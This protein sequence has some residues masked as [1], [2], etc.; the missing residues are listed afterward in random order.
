MDPINVQLFKPDS[1]R[2]DEWLVKWTNSN[3]NDTVRNNYTLCAYQ[4]KSDGLITIMYPYS[5]STY[6]SRTGV[7]ALILDEDGNLQI[8]KEW[9]VV[10]TSLNQAVTDGTSLSGIVVDDNL[11]MLHGGSY[12]GFTGCEG[13]TTTS[14][15]IVNLYSTGAPY[16]SVGRA[17]SN[18]EGAGPGMVDRYGYVTAPSANG[19]RISLIDSEATTAVYGST[20]SFRDGGTLIFPST[21]QWLGGWKR[22]RTTNDWNSTLFCAGTTSGDIPT[23]AT[24]KLF[25]RPGPTSYQYAVGY[26]SGA[27]TATNAFREVVGTTYYTMAF[28]SVADPW[29]TPSI[30]NGGSA[31]SF[32][33]STQSVTSYGNVHLPDAYSGFQGL[34]VNSIYAST[35]GYQITVVD[36]YYVSEI[37]AWRYLIGGSNAVWY[38]KP[39]VSSYDHVILTSRSTQTVWVMRLHISSI[40]AGLAFT[41]AG[42]TAVAPTTNFIRYSGFTDMPGTELGFSGPVNSTV[43]TPAAVAVGM[44]APTINTV[45]FG[46][47]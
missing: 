34:W 20:S 3:A 40:I 41:S 8:N 36:D 15:G 35:P 37:A 23:T 42:V 22:Y 26:S 47:D 19:C 31:Y 11:Y 5:D 9:Y 16:N 24:N 2:P 46:T 29:G 17:C 38:I 6:G 39:D 18:G 45:Q 33:Y 28:S 21:S 44:S 13:D 27:D 1:G 25:Y 43:T 7:A 10:N 4:R 30:R 32:G 14:G 12:I